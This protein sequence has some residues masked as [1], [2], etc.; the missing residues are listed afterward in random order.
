MQ[1]RHQPDGVDAVLVDD[2]LTQ[3][4][5]AVL[6]DH[7]DEVVIGDEARDAGV[8]RE[9]TDAHAVELMAARLQ[10]SD[11]LVHRGRGRAE[12]QHAVFGRL[13]RIGLQ[14]PRHHVL[15]GLE[16]AH[17]ALHVVGIDGAFLGIARVAVARGAA[18][19]VGALGRM[20]AGIG[21][22]GDAVAV[23][24]EIAAEVAAF[25]EHLR[26]HHLAAVVLL[27]IVPL[28]R[29]AQPVIHADVEIEHQED[30]GL[31]PLG[32]VERG[33]GEL[34]R[35]RRILREQQHVLG[36][37]VRGI[38][39][40]DHVALLGAGRHA[41]RGAGALDVHDH[42]RDLGEIGQADEFGHQR[43]ARTRGR[44]E[45]PRPVPGRA[46]HDADRGQF[47]LALHDGVF[48]LAGLGIVA[49]LLAV[50]GEGFRDRR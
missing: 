20:R 7:V 22:V 28:Q 41:G 11:R 47:V 17:Q 29:A 48:R 25:L 50:A 10:N 8:E 43:D 6:L 12:I 34:E 39:A 45:G 2:Q 27:G 3:L 26:R 1:D 19:E 24:V 40:G 9:G 30:R 15:R 13:R 49:I 16:L 14:R 33:G 37:A 5:V 35:L 42:G 32:E 23:D 21:A 4:R 38:G 18:G 31:Q 44:G 46:D 36:V